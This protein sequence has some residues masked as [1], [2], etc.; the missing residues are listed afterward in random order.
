M[1]SVLIVD[2]DAFTT[3]RLCRLLTARGVGE[4]MRAA[5]VARALDL[6]R[7]RP[8][9]VIVDL[10][11]PDGS[12]LEILH[13]IRRAQLSCR[14]VVSSGTRDAATLAAVASYGPELVLPKP[15]DSARLPIGRN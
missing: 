7:T 1:A 8:T 2:D 11:L 10:D 13:A 14:V 15:L 12:G 4:I 9:W 5:T 3:R 6:L